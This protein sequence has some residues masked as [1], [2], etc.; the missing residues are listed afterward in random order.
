MP[1][2][3]RSRLTL[4]VILGGWLV[5][6]GVFYVL[7]LFTAFGFHSAPGQGGFSDL[8]AEERSYAMLVSTLLDES[9]DW[10]AVKDPTTQDALTVQMETL[11][12]ALETDPAWRV[13]GAERLAAV[14]PPRRVP[15]VLEALSQRTPP[16][17][18]EVALQHA[19]LRR[20]GAIDGRSAVAFALQSGDEAGVAA[21]LGGWATTDAAAAWGWVERAGGDR[22]MLEARYGA[23]LQ[24]APVSDARAAQWLDALPLQ[25]LGMAIAREASLALYRTEGVTRA[26]EFAEAVTTDFAS[27]VSVLGS[28]LVAWS[29]ESPEAAVLWYERLPE[30]QRPWALE[31][32]GC[33]WSRVSG[34]EALAWIGAQAGSPARDTAVGEASSAWLQVEGPA[35]LGD[36]L[37][38]ADSLGPYQPALERLVLASAELDPET[39]YSWTE[40][41][42]DTS[43]RRYLQLVVQM[44]WEQRD[45]AGA[46]AFFASSA[47]PRTVSAGSAGEPVTVAPGETL[48]IEA[49]AENGPESAAEDTD[50]VQ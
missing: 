36:F 14:F 25:G 42:E 49:P 6:L 28:V 20:W 38:A 43:R 47:P 39:A 10:G 1:S 46:A 26:F 17:A 5:S 8:N 13:V 45:P 29:A 19:L 4:F 44:Q 16:T 34:R 35:P 41:V 22:S 12:V 24:A 40:W 31:L 21:A 2:V 9:V 30:N 23:V 37:N 18:A 33:G 32:I 7:G 48:I 11:L 27:R 15:A 3:K 50:S